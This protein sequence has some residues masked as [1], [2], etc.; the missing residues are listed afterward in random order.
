MISGYV[1]KSDHFDQAIAGF[2]F[3]YARQN[4]K[5]HNELVNAIRK[6]KLE[7]EFEA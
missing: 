4:E 5:D 3:A 2:S 1:S 6:G 7:A